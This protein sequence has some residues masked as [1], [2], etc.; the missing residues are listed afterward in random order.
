MNHDFA[1]ATDDK[2]RKFCGEIVAHM[3]RR[4]GISTE[5]AVGR[6]NQV[7]AGKDILG[8][9]NLVYHEVAEEWAMD[10]YFGKASKWWL[11]P[12]GLRPLPYP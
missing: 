1:F 6:I 5:E 2:S 4:G 8:D 10:I 7:W 11:N 3:V 12:P 9:L